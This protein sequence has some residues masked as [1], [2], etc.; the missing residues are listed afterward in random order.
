MCMFML[1]LCLRPAVHAHVLAI[2]AQLCY[3]L[4]LE[5]SSSLTP[6]NQDPLCAAAYHFCQLL[7]GNT[8]T[9]KNRTD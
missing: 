6:S 4:N 2:H 9:L 1:H 3:Q 5:Q 7:N 8:S